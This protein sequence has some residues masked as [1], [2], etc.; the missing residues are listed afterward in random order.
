MEESRDHSALVER[1]LKAHDAGPSAVKDAAMRLGGL[2]WSAFFQ[3]HP[4]TSG[5]LAAFAYAF[6]HLEIAGYE[7]LARVASRT[8]D[9][10]TRD[11]CNEILMQERA[12]AGAIAGTFER[13]ADAS[14]AE[15]TAPRA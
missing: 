9:E 3:A 6:E 1:R 14:L 11:A 2:N 15:T 13:A 10:H 4:D 7:L 5:K 12:A 8:G